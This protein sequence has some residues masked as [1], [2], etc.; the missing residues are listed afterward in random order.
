MKPEEI[1][2]LRERLEL[3]QRE[4]GEALGLSDPARIV[5][6]WEHG[7]R[8]G[9]AF[10]PSG[11]AR[12]AMKYLEGILDALELPMPQQARQRLLEALPDCL[13]EMA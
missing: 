5:R 7:E 9:A 12:A 3:S 6:A 1:K 13:R 11:S 10:L 4:F 8:K 2:A